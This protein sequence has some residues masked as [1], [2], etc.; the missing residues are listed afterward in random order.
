MSIRVWQLPNR[1][2]RIIVE[3]RRD[4][5]NPQLDSN[6][7]SGSMPGD[8]TSVSPSAVGCPRGLLVSQL[9]RDAVV[10]DEVAAKY[11]RRF[12]GSA[13]LINGTPRFGRQASNPSRIPHT[14]PQLNMRL[15]NGRRADIWHTG[16]PRPHTH[17]PRPD[18]NRHLGR[19]GRRS[20][21]SPQNL[22]MP[23]HQRLGAT[24]GSGRW[25][26]SRRCISHGYRRGQWGRPRRW[27]R[28][29]LIGR[30]LARFWSGGRASGGRLGSTAGSTRPLGRRLI[31]PLWGRSI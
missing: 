23:A 16:L 12:V 24:G 17:S 22:A 1:M 6:F 2:T 31:N 4:P 28:R 18:E 15:M 30:R 26:R 14:P 21:R 29:V 13:E 19:R 27:W 25:C 10:R 5:L 7:R 8:G 9:Q 20:A 11:L 3:P